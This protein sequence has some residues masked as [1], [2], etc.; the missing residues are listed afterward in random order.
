M[1]ITVNITILFSLFL[2]QRRRRRCLFI[3]FFCAALLCSLYLYGYVCVQYVHNFAEA[4]TL[5]TTTIYDE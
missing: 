1:I 2:R 4:R 3:L 5:S